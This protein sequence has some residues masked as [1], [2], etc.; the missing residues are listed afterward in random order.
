MELSRG[1]RI[2]IT[3][4][5]IPGDFPWQT[6]L[7]IS[8]V[9]QEDLGNYTCEVHNTLGAKSSIVKLTLKSMYTI[10][11]HVTIAYTH[12][13]YKVDCKNNNSQYTYKSVVAHMPTEYR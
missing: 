12:L 8:D 13:L 5:E 11:F 2:N 3:S 10:V 9:H 6:R 7:A 4:T 1:G